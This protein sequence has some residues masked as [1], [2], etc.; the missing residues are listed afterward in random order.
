MFFAPAVRTRAYAPAARA[1]NPSFERFLSDA[2]FTNGYG[3]PAVQQ[4]EK[5]WTV[6][7]DL[8]GVARE[9]LSVQIDGAVVRLETAAEAKRQFKAAWELP[10]EIDADASSAT[11]EHGVLTLVLGK[12]LPVSNARTLEVK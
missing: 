11:L 10:E 9:Q 6:T 2:F 3:A 1:F 12:K 5:S 8:P 7:L 4:D